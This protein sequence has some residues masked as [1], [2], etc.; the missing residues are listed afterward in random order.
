MTNSKIRIALIG[1]GGFG[2]FCLDAFREL[3]D[4]E[5]TVC[6]D[7]ITQSADRLADKY[8]AQ[9]LYDGME[10][11]NRDDVDLVHV[12][13]PPSS[14]HTLVLAALQAGKHV[15]CEKPLA[16]NTAEAD[17]MLAAAEKAGKILPVNFVMRYNEVTA[18]LKEILDSGLMGQPLYATMTNCA[19]DSK[20]GPEHWFW[21]RDLSGGIFIEH[22]VHF[23]DLYRYLLGDG[24]VIASHTETRPGTDQQDRV[25]CTLRHGP[26]AVSHHYHAFDQIMP[27]DRTSHRIVCELGDLRLEGWIPLEIRVDVAIDESGGESLRELLDGASLSTVEDFAEQRGH[28]MGR[29]KEYQ[30]AKRVAAAWSPAAD[31]QR[32]YA[33]SVRDLLADQ[34]AYIR[35]PA[36]KRIVTEA[37]G[38]EAV[39]LAHTAAEMAKANT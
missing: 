18:K 28:V 3:D 14:H 24:R 13:T 16:M 19:T 32:V 29:G 26:G 37:N 27:M 6:A 39:A 30:L 25:M 23:F 36:H 17:E 12:A 35:D 31:K 38:R 10:V 11:M 4:V 15:L 34:I 1:C 5:I 21:D 33:N 8:G 22:G 2:E 9:A 20:L 7:T